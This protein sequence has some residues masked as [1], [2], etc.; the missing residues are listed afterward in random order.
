MLIITPKELIETLKMY[1]ED[2]QLLVTWW[3]TEDVEMLMAD[4]G[5]EDVEKAQ[6]IWDDIVFDVDSQASDYAIS[7]VNDTLATLV[8]EKLE[9]K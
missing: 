6:E 2:E 9:G 3:S 1:K 5:A 4:S 7:S 8:Y